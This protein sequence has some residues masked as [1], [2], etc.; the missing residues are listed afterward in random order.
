MHF[1]LTQCEIV[2]EFDASRY[3]IFVI[4]D[5]QTS[6]F[7]YAFGF[8]NMYFRGWISSVKTILDF[9]EGSSSAQWSDNFKSELATEK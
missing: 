9:F 2:D 3:I 6:V 8:S 7:L 4:P 1:W 5:V